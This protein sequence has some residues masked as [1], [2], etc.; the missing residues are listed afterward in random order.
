MK[1]FFAHWPESAASCHR[2]A[3]RAARSSIPSLRTS[4][5]SFPTACL[6]P[7]TIQSCCRG[8]LC[9]LAI[10]EQLGFQ[11]S[12]PSPTSQ[13]AADLH[14]FCAQLLAECHPTQLWTLYASPPPTLSWADVGSV[15]ACD[16]GRDC[17]PCSTKFSGFRPKFSG[18]RPNLTSSRPCFFTRMVWAFSSENGPVSAKFGPG[19]TKLGRHRSTLVRFQPTSPGFDRIH[20]ENAPGEGGGELLTTYSPP[21]ASLS[22]CSKNWPNSAVAGPILFEL[23][24]SWSTSAGHVDVAPRLLGGI[25]FRTVSK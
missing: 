11:T 16:V 21:H 23:H 3:G 9:E 8:R 12:A 2:F 18:F 14:A 10:V 20:S 25:H 1:P 5:R 4:T 24:P 19:S 13:P 7:A 6:R 15:D 17:P 22:R